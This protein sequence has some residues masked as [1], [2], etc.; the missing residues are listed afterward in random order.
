MAYWRNRGNNFF[1]IMFL[2]MLFNLLTMLILLLSKLSGQL[3]LVVF[4]LKSK[5][6]FQDLVIAFHI[7]VVGDDILVHVS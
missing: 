6:I 2:I 5:L 4:N 7:H 3:L 1:A